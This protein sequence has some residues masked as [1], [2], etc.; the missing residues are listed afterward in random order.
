MPAATVG[1]AVM[2][3]ANA[4]S[5]VVVLAVA[6]VVVVDE[7]VIEALVVVTAGVASE[8]LRRFRHHLLTYCK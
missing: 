4:D 5:K 7:A 3:F 6:V 1:G 8:I 2:P